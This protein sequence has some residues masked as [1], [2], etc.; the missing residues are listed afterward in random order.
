M[1]RSSNFRKKSEEL[2]KE[3]QILPNLRRVVRGMGGGSE[4]Y[5]TK[6]IH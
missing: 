5:L 2:G 3:L 4:G 1:S 6:N